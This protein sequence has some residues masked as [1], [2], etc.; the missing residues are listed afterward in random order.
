MATSREVVQVTRGLATAA[1]SFSE[2][3][4]RSAMADVESEGVEIRYDEDGDP[5]FVGQIV[6]KGDFVDDA[7][8]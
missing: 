3:V 2:N 1:T 6:S 8:E 5:I 7:P 4:Q